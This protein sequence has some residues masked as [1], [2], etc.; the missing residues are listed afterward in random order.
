[1][2]VT[3]ENKSKTTNCR[4]TKRRKSKTMKLIEEVLSKENLNEAYKQ[5]IRNKAHQ[6]LM[7]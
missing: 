1:M 3:Y 7:K 2:S 5:V 6:V 4:Q